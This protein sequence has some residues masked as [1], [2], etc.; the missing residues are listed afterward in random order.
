MTAFDRFQRD[1]RDMEAFDQW[2]REA[3]PPLFLFAFRITRGYR[4]LAEDLCHD[5]ILAFVT[6]GH[7]KK[8]KN[9]ELASGYIRQSI[10]HA[11]SMLFERK[12]GNRQSRLLQ[13][14]P[15]MIPANR[16]SRRRMFTINSSI[17]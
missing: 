13:K 5:A 6:R 12:F 10:A 4:P 9:S 2:Y 14:P 1:P 8:A 17:D 3:Y 15:P 11:M 16:C 7:I